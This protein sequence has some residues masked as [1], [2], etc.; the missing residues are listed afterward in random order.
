[1]IDGHGRILARLGLFE[2]GVIDAKLPAALPPTVYARW[3]DSLTLLLIALLAAAAFICRQY[4]S[5]RRQA[6]AS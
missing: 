1:V 6:G 4:A 2:A 3:G 5:A